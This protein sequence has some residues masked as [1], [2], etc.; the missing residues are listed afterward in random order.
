MSSANQQKNSRRK[1]SSF[2]NEKDIETKQ[3]YMLINSD[4]LLAQSSKKKAADEICGDNAVDNANPNETLHNMI[5]KR[6]PKHVNV[7][8]LTVEIAV[9]TAVITFNEDE[10][11]LTSV[12]EK[13]NISA[14]DYCLQGLQKATFP[15]QSTWS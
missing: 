4:N 15:I 13:L 14:G 1:I 11:G 5:S 12:F 7:N 8:C 2:E 6:C 9:A 3:C 10:Q